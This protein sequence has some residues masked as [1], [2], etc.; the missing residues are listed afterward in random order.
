[1]LKGIGDAEALVW[2]RKCAEQ[3][4]AFAQCGLCNYKTLD[5][6]F[7]PPKAAEGLALVNRQKY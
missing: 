6:P 4:F 1:M 7:T 3:G 5:K 2:A